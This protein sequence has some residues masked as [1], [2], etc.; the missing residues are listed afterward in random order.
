M[1]ARARFLD[2]SHGFGRGG[3]RKLNVIL[4]EGRKRQIRRMTAA[5]GAHVV[6]LRRIRI[7]PVMLGDLP[8]GACAKLEGK[9]LEELLTFLSLPSH[10]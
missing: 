7:G 5:A 4:Q 9:A 1:R 2:A 6:R 8:L 3:K 10:P